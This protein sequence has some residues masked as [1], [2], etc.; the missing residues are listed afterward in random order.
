MNSTSIEHTKQQGGLRVTLKHPV[1]FN[2]TPSH[3]L[4]VHKSASDGVL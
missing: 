2:L 1:Y 4:L 3:A